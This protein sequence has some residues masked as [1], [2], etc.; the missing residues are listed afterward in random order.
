VS[1]SDFRRI[2]RG[3]RFAARALVVGGAL[4]AWDTGNAPIAS[5]RTAS[6]TVACRDPED[7]LE[8][9]PD[10]LMKPRRYQPCQPRPPLRPMQPS[11][12]SPRAQRLLYAQVDKYCHAQRACNPQRDRCE[13]LDKK[14]RYGYGCTNAREV[15]QQ[16]CF[17][18]GDPRYEDHMDELTQA[19]KSLRRCIEL[20]E[21]KCPR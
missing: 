11:R 13:I 16:Q 5:A 8:A 14:I 21:D 12:C 7:E 17:R 15:L 4:V 20:Q 18:S 1:T 3:A 2:A 9:E 10:A 19:F 6:E